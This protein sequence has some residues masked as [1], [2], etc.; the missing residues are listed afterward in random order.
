MPLNGLLI[1]VPILLLSVVLH[2]YAHA[3][4]AVAQGDPTPERAGRLTLNPLAHIDP[5]GSLLVPIGLWIASGGSAVFGWA[6]PVPTDPRL[7][8][9]P[10]R[11]DLLVSSAGVV[12]NFALAAAFV[13][14]AVA[15]AR[16]GAAAGSAGWLDVLWQTAQFGILINLLLGVFNLLPVPP[17]DGSHL[18]FHALPP[19]M[20]G[21]YRAF[22]RYGFLV[23]VAIMFVPGLLDAILWP[24]YRLYDLA[25][26]V[27]RLGA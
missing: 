8:R 17:L 5:I 1:A 16:A 14:V 22:G 7:Y 3:R 10:T 20:R 19:S 15:V 4:V 12:T 27:V 18:L 9:E 26:V 2:E 23:L 11:G 24:V 21:R 25:N 13:L 6:R